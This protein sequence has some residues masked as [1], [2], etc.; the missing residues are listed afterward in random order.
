MKTTK[1]TNNQLWYMNNHEQNNMKKKGWQW[2]RPP[3]QQQQQQQSLHFLTEFRSTKKQ[4]HLPLNKHLRRFRRGALGHCKGQLMAFQHCAHSALLQK[5]AT[6]L[7]RH[8]GQKSRTIVRITLMGWKMLILPSS[9]FFLR[10]SCWLASLEKDLF[11]VC[12]TLVGIC[13]NFS[14]VENQYASAGTTYPYTLHLDTIF[15][16]MHDDEL[17]ERSMTTCNLD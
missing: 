4:R 8:G 5:Y 6:R 12:C 16:H 13:E 15:S 1:G 17:P 14:C 9:N 2:W 7:Q 10:T 11:A 3:Q